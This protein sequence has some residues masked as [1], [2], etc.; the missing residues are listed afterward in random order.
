M[1]AQKSDARTAA[2]DTPPVRERDADARRFSTDKRQHVRIRIVQVRLQA[3]DRSFWN[4]RAKRI[5]RRRQ[6]GSDD[7]REPAFYGNVGDS[8]PI[9]L[10]EP[11][12][13]EMKI[14]EPHQPHVARVMCGSMDARDEQRMNE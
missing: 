9:G 1:L 6:A 5:V 10:G 8:L 13:D 11:C 3:S 12:G 14:V 4:E 2:T 7:W